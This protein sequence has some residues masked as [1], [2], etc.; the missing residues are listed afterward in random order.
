VYR[1][2]LAVASS[3]SD[4]PLGELSQEVGGSNQNAAQSVLTLAARAG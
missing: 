1:L 2:T 4:P 3:R